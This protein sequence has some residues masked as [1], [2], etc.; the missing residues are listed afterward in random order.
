E[1]LL[2]EERQLSAMME[3]W[4]V[5]GAEEELEQILKSHGPDQLE[6]ELQTER[7][8][9]EVE[10]HRLNE[11]KKQNGALTLTLKQLQGETEHADQLQ[12]HED[13]KEQLQA[14]AEK[15]A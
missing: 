8:E 1:R 11:L 5:L 3:S 10:Q 14:A 15:W 12:T 9:I 6:H 13:Q 4:D 2:E 7:S